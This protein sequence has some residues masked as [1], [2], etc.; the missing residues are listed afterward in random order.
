MDMDFN[1]VIT[2]GYHVRFLLSLLLKCYLN[3]NELNLDYNE[4]FTP[5]TNSSFYSPDSLEENA[6]VL[7]EAKL[8]FNIMANISDTQ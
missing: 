5:H 7:S 2:C 8:P 6:P 3:H 1:E 4:I